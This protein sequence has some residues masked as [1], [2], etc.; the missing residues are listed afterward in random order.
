ML[1]GVT[2]TGVS[3]EVL[4]TKFASVFPHLNERQRRLLAGAEAQALGRGGIAQVARASGLHPETVTAG[5]A[6]VAAGAP[7]TDR[8]RRPGG[9]RKPLT[10]PDPPLLAD[11]QRLVEDEARGDPERPL[12]W[13][14]KSTR[15]LAEALTALGHQVSHVVVGE[16]LHKLGFSLQ[17]NAKTR[18]GRQHPDRDGQFG[19]INATIS[20]ALDAGEPVIS[21]DTK[22]KELVGD[23]KNA[24]R[25]WRPTGAPV[26]V[27]THDFKDPALGKAIPYGV[28][29]LAN[30]EGWVSVGIDHDTAA[31]AV[32]SIR[33]WWEHLGSQRFGQATTLTIT[34]D[35]GGSNSYRTRLW[36]TELQRLADETGLAIRVCH[37]PPATSKWNKIEHRLF[38]FITINWRGK[39]LESRQV[40]IDLIASTT[41]S[42]GLKVHARLDEGTYPDKIKVTDAELAAVRLRGDPF[43]PEWNYTITPRT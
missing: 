4:A 15:Q 37:L 36:K 12:R 32:A 41:T 22:K 35:C 43:H 3:D 2:T 19:H 7:V 27:R 18:E 34:A 5:M 31:F 39:P 23:F 17:A 40:I 30:N 8:V 26:E 29:D 38:S 6:E 14:V 1:G 10:E 28:Y 20:A 42:T 24:G 13:T 9:G 21:V 16:L 25:E 11:L 33:S